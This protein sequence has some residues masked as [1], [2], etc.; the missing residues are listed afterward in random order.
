MKLQLNGWQRLW[1][2]VASVYFLVVCGFGAAT[3]PDG[4]YLEA[5]RAKFAIELALRAQVD[6][7]HVGGDERAELN[8]LR[9]LEKGAAR[10]RHEAYGDLTDT[11]LVQ[12]IRAKSDGKVDITALNEKEKRDAE[13]IRNDRLK[14]IY[15]AVGWWAIPVLA[16]YVLGSAIGWIVR[17]FRNRNEV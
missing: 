13:R 4:A 12:R 7:A 17:G 16:L 14:S 11:E 1:V 8:A 9:D 2:V 15:R 6:A 10:V 5:E 3:F